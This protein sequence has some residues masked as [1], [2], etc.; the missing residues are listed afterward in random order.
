MKSDFEVKQMKKSAIEL[1]LFYAATFIGGFFAGYAVIR[2]GMFA[3]SQTMNI[4][5]IGLNLFG[6]DFGEFLVRLFIMALYASAIAIGVLIPRY[7]KHDVRLISIFTTSA[8]AIF[9]SC[10]P[11]QTAST[12]SMAPVFFSMALEWSAFEGAMGY[13]AS[14]IFV[15]NDF[16]QM[17]LGG[18][19]YLCDKDEKY[20]I[21][22][23]FYAGTICSFFS[24]FIVSCAGIKLW[25]VRSAAIILAVLIFMTALVIKEKSLNK[26]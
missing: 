21:Q 22:F 11:T 4:I 3:S 7:T 24:G 23:L 5:S 12:L 26:R 2:F 9:L 6:K 16:R 13:Q 20:R 10:I 18:V 19:N 17:V 14:C 1:L 25:G 15:T 8:T